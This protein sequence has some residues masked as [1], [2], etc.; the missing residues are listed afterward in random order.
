MR[1][2]IEGGGNIGDRVG[3]NNLSDLDVITGQY[4]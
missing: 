2:D 4:I 1:K 3:F